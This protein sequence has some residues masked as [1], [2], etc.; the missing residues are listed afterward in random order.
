M[1]KNFKLK[2]L[3]LLDNFNMQDK[4][5]FST[6]SVFKLKGKKVLEFVKDKRGNKKTSLEIE[7]CTAYNTGN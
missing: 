4:C 3:I 5:L 1:K 6:T 2:W 7:Y